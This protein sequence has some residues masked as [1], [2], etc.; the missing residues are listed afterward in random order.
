MV[1]AMCAHIIFP[2]TATR[3]QVEL[4]KVHAVTIEQSIDS[5]CQRAE[6][7]L[8]RN[9]GPLQEKQL[10]TYVKRGD[11]VQVYL[12]YDGNLEL[13]FEGFV[14]RV[15]ADVPVVI[16]LRDGL[17]KLLQQ[18]FNKSYSST[19]IPTLVK[20]I[21]GDAFD[22]DA[23]DATVNAVR[24]EKVTKGEAFKALKDEFGLVTY[25]KGGKV[26]VGKLFDAEARTVK[27]DQE[28]N[29]KSSGLSYRL[30]D[31]VKLKVTAK[32]LLK[33]G[34]DV[35]VE[36]GDPD[37]QSRTLNY[38]G[39]TSTTEL[40]K[41]AEADMLKFKYD[42]YEGDFEAFGI[43]FCQYGDKVELTS[44]LYPERDGTYL[45]EGVTIEFGPDGFSRTIK[46]AQQWTR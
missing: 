27:Y 15:G 7:L 21:V 38:Y 9:I 11:A 3:Q 23:M 5:L 33:D 8:P 44:K 30:A 16:T 19:Y 4:R 14:E 28:R 39:I 45:A 40:K 17:W 24:F 26:F 34:S 31:D 42:G 41:L 20:D 12:G 22:I 29:V 46:L 25:L 32:S 37:G 10:K 36:V 2:A 18:P 6:L 1:L 43:P 35:T 13:E